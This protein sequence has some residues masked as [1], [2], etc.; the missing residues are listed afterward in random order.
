VPEE[1]LVLEEALDSKVRDDPFTC[2]CRRY[3]E[4]IHP[5]SDCYDHGPSL[6]LLVGPGL[7]RPG[8]HR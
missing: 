8:L 3:E 1:V 7:D 6:E 5:C 4:M 2:F